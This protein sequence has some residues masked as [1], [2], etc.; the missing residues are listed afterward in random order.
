[1]TTKVQTSELVEEAKQRCLRLQ[2]DTVNEPFYAERPVLAV[3]HMR[4]ALD[5]LIC[6]A[7]RGEHGPDSCNALKLWLNRTIREEA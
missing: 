3:T 4:M 5:E 1:M 6:I 2:Q 7:S